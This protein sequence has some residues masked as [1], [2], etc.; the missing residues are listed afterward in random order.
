M[1]LPSL[2]TALALTGA[3]LTGPAAAAPVAA[4]LVAEAKAPAATAPAIVNRILDAV[5]LQARFVVVASD[6]VPTAAAIVVEGQRCIVYNPVFMRAIN[7]VTHT[8]WSGVSVLAHEIGHH[9]NGHT[10]SADPRNQASSYRD[11]L[12]A[13]EFSGF[14]LRRMGAPS[15]AALAALSLLATEEESGTHPPRS[16]RVAAV[17]KGWNAG[18]LPGSTVAATL[19]SEVVADS[20]IAASP[21]PAPRRLN[22]AAITGQLVF[23]AAPGQ[24][25]YLTRQL[26]LV[27]N[28]PSGARVLGSLERTRSRRFPYRL[29][30]ADG[31]GALFVTARGIV[32]DADGRRVGQLTLV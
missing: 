30:Q 22:P 11:E 17:A 4:M 13:D 16:A 21:E 15:E 18:Q 20:V 1:K 28:D 23:D 29:R 26:H 9:L 3:V 12:E 5:G 32:V 27:A 8:S 14:V 25:L 24:V 6:R 2:L 19:G 10:L 7:H 31:Q